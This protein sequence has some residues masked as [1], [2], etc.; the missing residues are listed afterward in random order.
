MIFIYCFQGNLNVC[1]WTWISVQAIAA[2]AGLPS[3]RGLILS[4]TFEW[5]CGNV[6]AIATQPGYNF[7]V[8]KV[9][10]FISFQVALCNWKWWQQSNRRDARPCY[11]LEDFFDEPFSLSDKLFEQSFRS[12]C[13]SRALSKLLD[14]IRRKK[15]SCSV[16]VICAAIV[17]I[18]HAAR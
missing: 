3:L 14:F 4:R 13:L 2:R 5:T 6:Q 10:F 17:Q 18:C 7:T 12:K 11:L 8:D 1:E 15:H 16:L 9:L